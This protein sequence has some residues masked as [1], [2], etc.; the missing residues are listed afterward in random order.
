[1]RSYGPSEPADG[2]VECVPEKRHAWASGREQTLLLTRF[3]D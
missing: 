1:M 2:V 3:R